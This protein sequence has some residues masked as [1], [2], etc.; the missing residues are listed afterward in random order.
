MRFPVCFFINPR[1]LLVSTVTEYVDT[2]S[3]IL[4]NAWA[5]KRAR[6]LG[7]NVTWCVCP[8]C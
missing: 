3:A 5:R 7:K 8:G 4:A 6:K 1:T 2:S